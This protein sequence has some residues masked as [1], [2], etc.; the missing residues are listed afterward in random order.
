[1]ND[2][3]RR[4]EE[5]GS[6]INNQ[7]KN[8]VEKYVSVSLALDE[9]TNIGSIAQLLIFIRRVTKDFQ[10]SKEHFSMVNLKN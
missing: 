8:D 9:S 1:M 3:T 5:I 4:V 7:L 6:D 10:I 2:N